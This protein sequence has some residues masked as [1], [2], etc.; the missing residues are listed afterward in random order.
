MG[1]W[2][3]GTFENDAAVDWMSDLS[4]DGDASM[5]RGG[6]STAADADRRIDSDRC[7]EA[8][9]AC[10]IVAAVLGRSPSLPDNP[11]I[12]EQLPELAAFA[13]GATQDVDVLATRMP[14]LIE[15]VELARRAVAAVVDPERSQLHGLWAE[16]VFLQ[17]WLAVVDNLRRRLAV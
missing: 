4:E 6:L 3:K 15:D 10:E 11:R 9:A 16:T 12:A 1:A 8:L 7:C 13:I 2:G 17:E 5:V 14:E